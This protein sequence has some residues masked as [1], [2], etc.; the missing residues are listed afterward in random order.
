RKVNLSALQLN[1]KQKEAVQN[2]IDAEHVSIVHGP[3]GTGK[4][5][6][7]VAAIEQLIAQNAGTILVTAPSNTAV[8][9]LTEKLDAKGIEVTRIGNP[10]RVS[11]RLQDLTYEQ[12]ILQHPDA[13]EIK[14]LKKQ[15]AAYLD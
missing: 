7:L 9:L 11:E 12:K 1:E 4:T 8:D 15:A 3:P 6:T 10:V 2:I 14:K 13:K 5:T